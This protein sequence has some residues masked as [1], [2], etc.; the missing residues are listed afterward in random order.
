M[1][2]SLVERGI[3]LSTVPVRDADLIVHILL[4]NAGRIG[5]VARGARKSKRRFMG[6]IDLFDCA[7]F[8]L[9]RSHRSTSD[10][11]TLSGLAN[12]EPWA[13]L[14]S[15]LTSLAISS[16]C[17]EAASIFAH[18]GDPEGHLLFAPL[19]QALASINRSRS[20]REL[21]QIGIRFLLQVLA[22][23]GF[24]P[25]HDEV[26]LRPEIRSWWEALLAEQGDTAAPMDNEALERESLATVL[27]L[28]ERSADRPLRSRAMLSREGTTKSRQ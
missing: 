28:I 19:H 27:T 24:H 22:I 8:E 15:S 4:E 7:C 6:G 14:R 9:T 21:H 26:R 23:S 25:L 13:Q 12:R 11:W 17:L 18:E 2:G 1:K 16:I 20:T 3:V 10:L 5:A